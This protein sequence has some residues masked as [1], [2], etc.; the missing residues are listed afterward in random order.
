MILTSTDMQGCFGKYEMEAA[1]AVILN[2]MWHTGNVFWWSEDSPQDRHAFAGFVFLCVH[3]WIGT[4]RLYGEEVL[5]LT[6][7]A[8][9]RLAQR[10]SPRVRAHPLIAQAIAQGIVP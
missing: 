1:M 8:V 10:G 6:Q 2:N 4:Q 7:Q 3:G 9:I 5:K